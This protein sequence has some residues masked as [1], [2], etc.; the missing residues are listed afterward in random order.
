MTSKDG[1]GVYA[2]SDTRFEG[3]IFGRDSLEVAEDLLGYKPK[4]VER[5]ILT[6]ASLQGEEYNRDREEEPGKII[7]E[8][9]R[10]IADGRPLR[11][12]PQQIF[13]ILSRLWGGDDLTMAYYGS[14]DATPLFIRTVF[15]YT[16]LYGNNI[17]HK[18]ALLRSGHQISLTIAVENSLEW[19]CQK[20]NLS[21]SGLL[22]YQ[23]Q[24]P[25]GLANQA[26]KDSSEF[27]VHENGKSA[28]HELPIASVEVQAVAYDALVLAAQHFGH[29]QEHFNEVAKR[30]RDR[31]IE[32]LWQPKRNYFALGIDYGQNKKLRVIKTLTANPAELLD[33]C[34]FDDLSDEDKQLYVGSIAR[35]IMG[36]NFLTD[37]GIRSR[38]LSEADVVKIWD[39]H[40]S[41]TTW[42]KETYDIA[43]GLRRQGFGRLAVELENRLINIVRAL[44]AYPEFIYVDYRGRILGAASAPHR[45]AQTL[46]VNNTDRPERMQAWTVSAV[47][48]ILAD[49]RRRLLSRP[50]TLKRRSASL[51]DSWQ[52]S[53]ET[54]ILQHIPLVPQ[55]RSSRALSARYP[56]YPYKLKS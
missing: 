48:A 32:L 26:W 33:S 21:R 51:P 37:A 46:V 10:A 1:L 9:R 4:L 23:R 41:Y 20:L 55:L 3:A 17:L 54:E 53:A 43:K 30:L 56:A 22:E 31:T 40:G 28:N 45:H 14:V 18:K 16:D 39:Y 35:E 11:E 29:K 7:H 34:L 27:Y 24:N 8:Y 6:L 36:S 13:E 5:I 52:Y 49:R 50:V 2:S 42:P 38:A 44:K 47:Y 19:L 15:R 12:R 25:E